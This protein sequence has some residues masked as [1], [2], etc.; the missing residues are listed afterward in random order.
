MK[1]H[2]TIRDALNWG[3]ERL[4]AVSDSASLDAQVL[5]V[6]VLDKDRAYLL[7]HGE[8]LLNSEQQSHYADLIERA[9]A[10]EPLPYILGRRAFYDREFHVSPGVLI[11]RPE[12]EILLEAALIFARSQPNTIVVDV[13]TGSGAI[14]VTLAANCADATVYA[15]DISPF[16]LKV[17]GFNADKFDARVTFFEGDLL[18][19]LLER[20]IK[21]DLLLANLPYIASGDIPSLAVSRY[22]PILALDGGAD[23][24]NLVRRLLEQAPDVCNP[25]ACL[26]L[27]IG[28][29]QGVAG[30]ELAQHTFPGGQTQILKDY[31]G[32]DRIV[33]IDLAG[34]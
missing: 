17:A 30:L 15:T 27:E 22:E 28:S 10:G 9:A 11:P 32:F 33:R 4:Q 34:N 16:A 29:D 25:G 12:T 8:Q 31:A 3:K 20:K 24:L 21:V 14:A 19:P 13:G 5:L 2:L 26:L 23:G 6:S 7:A 1:T 18:R